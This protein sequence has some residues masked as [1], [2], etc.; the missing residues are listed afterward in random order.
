MGTRWLTSFADVAEPTC[1]LV[2]FPHAGGGTS[3][4]QGWQRHTDAL[5]VSA[6]RLPGRESRLREPA[7][8]DLDELVAVL[9][10]AL[11]RL[12]D[13]PYAFY[14]HSM[15]ALVAYELTR[16]L[17]AAGLPLPVGLFVAGMDAPQRLDLDR[18]HDL[19]R[20]E[21][22]AWLVGVNGLDPEVLEYPALID[23]M[24]PTI[25]ADLAVV[26]DYTH[27]PQPPLPVPL[28]VLRGRDDVQV[29]VE[30]SGGWAELTSAGCAVTDLDG[31]HFFVQRHERLV[32]S[33]I[34]ADLVK[35][36][37]GR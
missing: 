6:V 14:G 7:I 25:R 11:A 18:A 31:D 5:R 10:T 27:R 29:S 2:C 26:E 17:R 30:G 28:H 3:V 4:F 22:V 23:L 21:L 33:L 37:A 34:E 20:D 35:E 1:E 9:V 32:V 16:A 12:T 13:R 8:A 15:G 36:G 24:L 19:P